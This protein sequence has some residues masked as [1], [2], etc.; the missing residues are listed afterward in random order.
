MFTARNNDE[1]IIPAVISRDKMKSN[2]PTNVIPIP[3]KT[4]TNI[5]PKIK[6]MEKEEVEFSATFNSS[7]SSGTKS[8]CKMDVALALVTFKEKFT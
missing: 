8:L 7:K 2:T 4:R 5:K 1:E 3:I 6:K